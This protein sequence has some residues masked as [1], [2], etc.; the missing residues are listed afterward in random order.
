MSSFV[1]DAAVGLGRRRSSVPAPRAV[2]VLALFP[3][4][5]A[6]RPGALF[7][8]DRLGRLNSLRNSAPKPARSA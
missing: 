4:A 3:T 1:I 7:W 8:F 5:G 6:V 2:T